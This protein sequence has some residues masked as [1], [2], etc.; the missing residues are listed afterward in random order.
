MDSSVTQEKVICAFRPSRRGRATNQR[1]KG[2]LRNDPVLELRWTINPL[3]TVAVEFVAGVRAFPHSTVGLLGRFWV[4]RAILS[5]WYI[6]ADSEVVKNDGDSV[7]D[8]RVTKPLSPL[9]MPSTVLA[10]FV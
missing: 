2:T 8:L 3:S 10:F 7:L 5:S 6:E 9:P 1:A 4:V